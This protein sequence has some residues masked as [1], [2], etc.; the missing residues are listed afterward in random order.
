MVVGEWCVGV[1]VCV[2][3]DSDGRGGGGEWWWV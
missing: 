3:G 2:V 1:M